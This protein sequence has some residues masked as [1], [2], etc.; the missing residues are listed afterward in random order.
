MKTNKYLIVSLFTFIAAIAVMIYFALRISPKEQ[1]T[2]IPPENLVNSNVSISI[3]TLSSSLSVTRDIV[4]IHLL[5]QNVP[6][7]CVVYVNQSGYGLT[8]QLLFCDPDK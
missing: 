4:T 3:N 1:R 6:Q 8:S 5:R 7:T 2:T